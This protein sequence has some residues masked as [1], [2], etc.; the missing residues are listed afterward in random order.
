MCCA[1]TSS[2]CENWLRSPYCYAD[3][4]RSLSIELLQARIE[5]LSFFSPTF[6]RSAALAKMI[7]VEKQRCCYLVLVEC[8]MSWLDYQG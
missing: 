8:E 3:G 5:S 2:F 1:L 6:S 7:M 4:A